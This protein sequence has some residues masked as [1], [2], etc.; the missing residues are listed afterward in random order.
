LT[1]FAPGNGKRRRP[2]RALRRFYLRIA[3]VKKQFTVK[4]FRMN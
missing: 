1:F 3:G 4:S 2:G